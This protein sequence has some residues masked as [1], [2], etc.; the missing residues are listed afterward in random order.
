MN[1]FSDYIR[2]TASATYGPLFIHQ[3]SGKPL[4]KAEVTSAMT[5]LIKTS[6][7]ESIP[8][9]H[10]IRRMA[11]SLAFFNGMQVS[12]MSELTGWSSTRV[13][14][15]HYLKE[16]SALATVS[17]VMGRQLDGPSGTSL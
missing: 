7:P 2:R 9:S 16:V 10:D 14:T 15:K 17:V 11:S 4:T 3:A 8:K 6:N 1:N 12:D 5:V 13:F